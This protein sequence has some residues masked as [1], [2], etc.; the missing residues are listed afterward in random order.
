MINMLLSGFL[1]QD[2]DYIVKSL[3]L[4]VKNSSPELKGVMKSIISLGTGLQRDGIQIPEKRLWDC[5]A[6]RVELTF[7]SAFNQQV[8]PE[9]RLPTGGITKV[10]YY[11]HSVIVNS[12]GLK[13][14]DKRLLDT[15]VSSLYNGMTVVL[16]EG[17]K[18]SKISLSEF[19]ISVFGVGSGG[20]SLGKRAIV[21]FDNS[22]PS[23]K[24]KAIKFING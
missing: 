18:I 17:W 14:T 9:L 4:K 13:A 23:R 3:E 19:E 8:F 12:K 5:F 6:P 2:D 20:S 22:K 7:Y 21:E 24:I 15:C 11:K 16:S 1:H 10:S